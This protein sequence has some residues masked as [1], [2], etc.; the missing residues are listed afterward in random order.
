VP[1][2]R[3][4]EVLNSNLLKVIFPDRIHTAQTTLDYSE[5]RE[6]LVE[7]YGSPPVDWI[8]H[9]KRIFSFRDISMPPFRDAIEEGSEDLIATREWVEPDCDV[10]R[11]LFVQLLNRTL[12]EMVHEPLAF[13]REKRYLF[14]KLG[15][16]K[17]T[18]SFSYRSFENQTSRKVEGLHAAGRNE[19]LLLQAR[20]LPCELH[21]DR[22]RLVPGDRARLPLH[23]G[24]LP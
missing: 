19:A 9:G 12:G 4:A 6:S 5:I 15:R 3:S 20:C 17:Q 11:R 24:R 14:F 16:G 7:S 8:V 2:T 1:S 13:W 10:T 18:R 21:P 22:R 23:V